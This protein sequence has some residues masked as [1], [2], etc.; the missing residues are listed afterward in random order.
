MAFIADNYAI[1]L[2]LLIV[3]VLPLLPLQVPLC[4]TCNPLTSLVAWPHMRRYASFSA[5]SQLLEST[6]V[7]VTHYRMCVNARKNNTTVALIED[8]KVVCTS[9]GGR[10]FKKAMRSGFEPAYQAVVGVL[11]TFKKKRQRD[12]SIR[13]PVEVELKGFG[14]GR[15]AA[16]QALRIHQIKISHLVDA[17]PIPHGGCRPK[18]QRRL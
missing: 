17:T 9:S 8:G 15:E 12:F 1:P 10:F 7:A 4:R 5:A 3:L 2:L 14:P 11:E 13:D 6:R 16:I 18:K